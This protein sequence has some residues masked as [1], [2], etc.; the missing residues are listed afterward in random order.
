LAWSEVVK[1]SRRI[2][3]AG[4]AFILCAILFVFKVAFGVV[5]VVVESLDELLDMFFDVVF[6]ERKDGR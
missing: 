3:F 6:E 5:I 2:A 1:L 4:L